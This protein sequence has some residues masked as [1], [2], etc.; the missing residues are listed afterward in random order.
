MSSTETETKLS[1]GSDGTIWSENG[2]FFFSNG[3]WRSAEQHP[4][5][6]QQNQQNQ[7]VSQGH[8]MPVN[9]YNASM[10]GF[11]QNPSQLSAAVSAASAHVDHRMELGR[12]PQIQGQVPN[13]PVGNDPVNPELRR[14][15]RTNPNDR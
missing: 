12:N 1:A 11:F 15:A 10:M 14:V 5:F 6:L 9:P 7:P 3:Q 4:S 13:P 2:D 8:Y